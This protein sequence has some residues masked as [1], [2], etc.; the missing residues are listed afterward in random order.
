MKVS[1]VHLSGA[2]FRKVGIGTRRVYEVLIHLCGLYREEVLLVLAFV[3]PV[4]NQLVNAVYLAC[5]CIERK[6]ESVGK[7]LE[8]FFVYGGDYALVALFVAVYAVVKV[9]E[10]LYIVV[11]H[12]DV[13][14]GSNALVAKVERHYIVIVGHIGGGSRKEDVTAEN[15]GHIPRGYD[16][17][18]EYLCIVVVAHRLGFGEGRQLVIIAVRSAERYA[19]N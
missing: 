17:Q 15:L 11:R 5:A 8:I 3:N 1:P 9:V 2:L 19:V 13:G 4:G 12:R 16:V 10:S 6:A 14:R 18:I 7:V